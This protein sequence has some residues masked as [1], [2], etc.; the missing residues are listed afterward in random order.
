M[1]P[2]DYTNYGLAWELKH[3]KSHIPDLVAEACRRLE[4]LSGAQPVAQEARDPINDPEIVAIRTALDWISTGKN[5]TGKELADRAYLALG[6][7][8]SMLAAP[9]PSQGAEPQMVVAMDEGAR[10]PRII[11]WNKLAIGTHW[12]YAAPHPPVSAELPPALKTAEGV[13]AAM[14]RGTLPKISMI[15]CAHT[16]GEE[17]VAS[18]RAQI[19]SPVSADAGNVE[20]I[21]DQ[22]SRHTV[23][24]PYAAELLKQLFDE[25]PDGVNEIEAALQ[26]RDREIACL[27]VEAGKGVTD[28]RATFERWCTTE[29]A[30]LDTLKVR[31]EKLD[32][33]AYRSR[34]TFSAWKGWYARSR[35]IFPSSSVAV[36]GEVSDG[37]IDAAAKKLAEC[38]DYPWEHMPEK[39][40]EQMRSH[41]R[42]VLALAGSGVKP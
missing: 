7:V 14:L 40:R 19:E 36:S 21:D 3:I 2:T 4:A 20:W 13:H 22:G 18:Y 30:E 41:V 1:K 29:E 37:Q 15:Q 5:A 12:L 16:H 25:W 23:T 38:F 39:G 24:I 28:E 9:Q 33:E 32:I 11:S 6:R 42:A 35:F 34:E 17:A 26:W 8:R 10:E 27:K 31:N